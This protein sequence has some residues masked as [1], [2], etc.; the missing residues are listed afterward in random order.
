MRLIEGPPKFSLF[1]REV[2]QFLFV[3]ADADIFLPGKA[4]RMTESPPDFQQDNWPA[5]YLN[6]IKIKVDLGF[7]QVQQPT[8]QL[9]VADLLCGWKE[10]RTNNLMRLVINP[11]DQVRLTFSR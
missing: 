1:F 8:L 2:L 4:H 5:V 6:G 9:L 3:R 7:Q 11:P 10:G